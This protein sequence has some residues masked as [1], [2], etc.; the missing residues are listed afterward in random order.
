MNK[1]LPEI[2][3]SPLYSVAGERLPNTHIIRD[4]DGAHR[5]IY[6][7][8]HKAREIEIKW[9]GGASSVLS[10][11]EKNILGMF[12]ERE[13]AESQ[14]LARHLLDGGSISFP[15]GTPQIIPIIN[16]PDGGILTTD[17]LRRGFEWYYNVKTQVFS[18]EVIGTDGQEFAPDE[19]VH[20]AARSGVL[21]I[22]DSVIDS[23]STIEGVIRSFAEKLATLHPNRK[24]PIR[25]IIAANTVYLD[26]K[27]NEGF[28]P[29]SPS[30][31]NTRSEF[32]VIAGDRFAKLMKE[33]R[34]QLDI[35]LYATDVDFKDLDVAERGSL[36]AK[37]VHPTVQ[38]EHL[39]HLSKRTREH[40]EFHIHL[41]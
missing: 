10:H 16:C 15:E 8:R 1:K 5:A 24:K 22:A 28:D 29:E 34:P 20:I 40:A 2:A 41:P 14:N 25:V 38:E 12:L 30:Y 11:D 3:D 4:S 13:K 39:A 26:E 32:K 18:K 17:G 31:P 6:K 33:F 19:A 35:H 23:G 21:V 36:I 9:N 27:N 37:A 7:L